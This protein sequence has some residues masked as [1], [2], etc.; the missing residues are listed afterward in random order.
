VKYRACRISRQPVLSSR[1][2]RLVSDQCKTSGAVG[3]GLRREGP[4][5][6]HPTTWRAARERGNLVGLTI[7]KSVAPVPL[8]LS[9]A[10]GTLPGKPASPA[11]VSLGGVDQP[12]HTPAG[13]IECAAVPL[14]Q[15]GT[16]P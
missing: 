11:S 5:S 10:P 12:A 13:V 2:C 9:R 4:Y 3:A 15:A 6:S 8:G 7:V 14:A 1:C 16:F